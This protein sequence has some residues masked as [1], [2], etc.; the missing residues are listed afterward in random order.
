MLKNMSTSTDRRNNFRV[1]FT[2][3]I[4]ADA[5]F[6]FIN[7]QVVD[8]DKTIS[9]LILDLSST[10]MK[11]ETAL[12]LP[13][14]IDLIL[15]IEFKIENEPIKLYGKALWKKI[16]SPV[17]INYGLEFI[18]FKECEQMKLVRCLNIYQIKQRRLGKVKS[19][20]KS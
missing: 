10:G 1:Y 3:A 17:K 5:H 7:G 15:Q 19:I 20:P 12:D 2:Y 4:S 9:L 18:H 16:L 13:S 8:L 11:M 6:K 14:D